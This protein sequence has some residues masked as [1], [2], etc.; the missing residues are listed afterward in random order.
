MIRSG[1]RRLANLTEQH[2]LAS[3]CQVQQ[4]QGQPRSRSAQRWGKP[5]QQK[6][7]AGWGEDRSCSRSKCHSGGHPSLQSQPEPCELRC[8]S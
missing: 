5:L 7:A 6:G 3:P 1:Q 4:P 2:P 8:S